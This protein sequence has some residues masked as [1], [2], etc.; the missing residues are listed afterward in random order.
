LE[1]GPK[2][3]KGKGYISSFLG[4]SLRDDDDDD[5]NDDDDF[6]EKSHVSF[7]SKGMSAL[8]RMYDASM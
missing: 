8:E 1:T 4:T 3:P 2:E 6:D 5:D 7:I